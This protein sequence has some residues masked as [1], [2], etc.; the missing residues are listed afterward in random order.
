MVER[1]CSDNFDAGGGFGLQYYGYNCTGGE[2]S[3]LFVS[4]LGN[5]AGESVLDQT[6]DTA[7]QIANLA[8][9]TNVQS[10]TYWSGT[11]YAPGTYGVWSFETIF[12]TQDSIIKGNV[13]YA[14]AVRPGDVAATVPE[15]QTLVLALMAMGGAMLMRRKQP[16]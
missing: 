1:R 7:E 6:G 4:G 9:F 11:E 16:R 2:L 5:K 12:G 14:V 13:L 10:D 15:P 3:R 8:F